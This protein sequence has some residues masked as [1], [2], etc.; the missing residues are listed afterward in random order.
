[1]MCQNSNRKFNNRIKFKFNQKIYI[2]IIRYKIMRFQ[3]LM[4]RNMI[5]LTK[6]KKISVLRF[7]YIY[8]YMIVFQLKGNTKCETH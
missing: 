8:I 5:R 4:W 3:K 1:M 7:I 2:K 6:N